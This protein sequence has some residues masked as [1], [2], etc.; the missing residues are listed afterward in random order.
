MIRVKESVS[1][2]RPLSHFTALIR[3]HRSPPHCSQSF[4]RL[5]AAVPRNPF[6]C[7][8]SFRIFIRDSQPEANEYINSIKMTRKVNGSLFLFRLFDLSFETT[9]FI[10]MERGEFTADLKLSSRWKF[11]LLKLF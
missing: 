11:V 10:A 3:L 9:R 6:H 1:R 2:S 7:F 8:G 5:Q 4:C